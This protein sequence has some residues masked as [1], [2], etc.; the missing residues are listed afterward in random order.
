[1]EKETDTEF[2]ARMIADGFASVDKRFEAMDL[3]F[4]SLEKVVHETNRRIDNV[5]MP[6][7]ED[8]SRRIKDLELHAA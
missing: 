6:T 4:D 1:M 2:L 5:I 3:R 7:Q 8:H